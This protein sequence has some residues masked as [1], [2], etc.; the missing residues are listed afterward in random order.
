MLKI[1][2]DFPGARRTASNRRSEPMR[3][4]EG[5]IDLP[6]ANQPQIER[7]RLFAPVVFASLRSTSQKSCPR[8]VRGQL[9]C[10]QVDPAMRD[11][12]AQIEFET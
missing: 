12:L 5:G 1:L 10:W 6:M 7:K 9:A 11:A 3:P 2:R 8:A 4:A